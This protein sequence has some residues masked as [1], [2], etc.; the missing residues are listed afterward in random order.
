MLKPYQER[1]IDEKEELDS[2]IDALR[3]F[4]NTDTFQSLQD[5][6][7]YLLVRQSGV[8]ATYSSI[9]GDRI[10]RFIQE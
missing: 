1:V 9:L 7:K 3:L 6:D 4:F 2:K 8:M 5:R 10:A